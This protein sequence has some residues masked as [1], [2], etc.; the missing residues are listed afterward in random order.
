[1]DDHLRQLDPKTFELY[2]P[3]WT[4]FIKNYFR[5]SNEWHSCYSL[6]Q[7]LTRCTQKYLFEMDLFN[8]LTELGYKTRLDYRGVPYAKVCYNRKFVKTFY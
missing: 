3:V 4:E 7:S 1:M 8:L 2:K 5:K 6:K